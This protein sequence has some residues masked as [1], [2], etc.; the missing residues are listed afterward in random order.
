ME[1]ETYSKQ[2]TYITLIA[3]SIGFIGF[4]QHYSIWILML[5]VFIVPKYYHFS[6]HSWLNIAS[7][8]AT[9]FVFGIINGYSYFSIRDFY[10]SEEKNIVPTLGIYLS[11]LTIYHYFEFQMVNN[12]HHHQLC[13]TIHLTGIF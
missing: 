8:T 9:T 10:L 6:S 3:F 7:L 11:L 1:K 13:H 4:V 12:F 5:A 2:I